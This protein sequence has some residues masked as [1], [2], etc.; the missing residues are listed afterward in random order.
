[1]NTKNDSTTP[2]GNTICTL[3]PTVFSKFGT[4]RV[5]NV[6]TYHFEHGG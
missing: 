4:Q 6:I 5:T 1:M 2:E 3:L